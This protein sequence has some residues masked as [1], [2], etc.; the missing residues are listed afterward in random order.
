[1]QYY[2]PWEMLT[3][4]LNADGFL[5]DV[6]SLAKTLWKLGTRQRYPL[7]GT[8]FADQEPMRMSTYTD[9]KRAFALDPLLELA[10]RFNPRE[11]ISMVEFADILKNWLDYS[12]TTIEKVADQSMSLKHLRSRVEVVKGDYAQQLEFLREH[13]TKVESEVHRFLDLFET[14]LRDAQRSLNEIDFSVAHSKTKSTKFPGYQSET[15]KILIQT[16]L[17]VYLTKP[18][19]PLNLEIF[20]GV[21]VQVDNSPTKYGRR[22]EINGPVRGLATLSHRVKGKNPLVGIR[23]G[24]EWTS[25]ITKQKVV[26]AGSTTFLLGGPNE[27]E[28]FNYLQNILAT[29]LEHVVEGGLKLFETVPCVSELR[30]KKDEG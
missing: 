17:R 22:L 20:V 5:A 13:N 18:N 30:N 8:I 6:Y 16:F 2:I 15:N 26:G 21:A 25:F 7:F 9:H 29:N 12:A 14:Q 23:K 27:S 10:T 28:A 1:S 24:G 11:R 4:P 3:D 19:T